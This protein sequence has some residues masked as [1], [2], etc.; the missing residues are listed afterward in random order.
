MLLSLFSLFKSGFEI[1]GNF[2]DIGIGLSFGFLKL[3]KLVELKDCDWLMWGIRGEFF[4]FFFILNVLVVKEG[5]LIGVSGVSIGCNLFGDLM[6]CKLEFECS[7]KLGGEVLEDEFFFLEFCNDLGF[8]FI[9]NELV[10]KLEKKGNWFMVRERL[11][12]LL[13]LLM[14]FR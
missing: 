14:L 5:R 4:N 6:I 13:K 11:L 2:V 12:K 8:F 10:L 3:L 1:D 9:R 7:E